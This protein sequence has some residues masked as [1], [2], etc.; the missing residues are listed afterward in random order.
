MTTP[1]QTPDEVRD[2]LGAYALGALDPEERAQVDALLLSDATARTELHELEQAAAWLGHA[3]LR[4]PTSAWDAIQAEVQRDLTP[5]TSAELLPEAHP[6][7]PTALPAPTPIRSR[8]ERRF[9]RLLVA[10][11]AVLVLAL[12]A[13]G[14]FT[15][16]DRSSDS[17]SITN[18]YESALS[19]PKAQVT[20]LR[21]QDGQ[22]T[23]R[24][25]V[26]RNHTGYL[27]DAAMPELPSGR[28]YQLWS[29]TPDGPVSVGLMRG[30][31]AI[32]KFTVAESTSALAV[33]NEPRGGSPAPTGTPVVSGD[34]RSV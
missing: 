31:P 32:R 2:L 13:V 6:E 24:A 16:V 30:D 11:A 34:L 18:Q 4:P 5:G 14:V 27:A 25:V 20:T 9:S 7:A 29:I 10:A 3:S 12:G 26:L 1:E 8:S 17:D 22:Y 15:I 28:D 33:T 19:N 21:S 23:A